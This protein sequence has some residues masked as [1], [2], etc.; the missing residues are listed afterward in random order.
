LREAYVTLIVKSAAKKILLIGSA[1]F[2][3]AQFFRPAKNLGEAYGAKEI[4]AS[5]AAPAEVKQLLAVAC[6]DC[7]SNRTHYPWYAEVQPVAW[8]LSQH[9]REG[10]AALNFSEFA[11]LTKKRAVGK[12][13]DVADEV[14]NRHMP[15]SSYTLIHRDARLTDAQIKQLVDWFDQVRGEIAGE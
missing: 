8:W 13:E 14:T 7:H 3:A 2:L 9:V 15:L 10:K 5:H 1:V 6:Y 12:L 11:A 4:T